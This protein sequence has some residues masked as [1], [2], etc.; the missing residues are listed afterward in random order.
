MYLEQDMAQEQL[1]RMFE[2]FLPTRHFRILTRSDLQSRYVLTVG[3]EG[4]KVD[5]ISRNFEE[6]ALLPIPLCLSIRSGELET[7]FHQM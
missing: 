3:R 4:R 5:I 7:K 2:P 1:L 6:P